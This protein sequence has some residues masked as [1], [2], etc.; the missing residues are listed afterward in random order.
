MFDLREHSGLIRSLVA[1]E[2]K[3]DENWRWSVKAINKSKASIFW[4]YLEYLECR[5]TCFTLELENTGEGWWLNGR[6]E[7]GH[8]IFTEIVEDDQ[9]PF[10]NTP[11]E[12][13]IRM[14]VSSIAGTAHNCY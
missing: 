1:E 10:L 9:M 4:G 8:S 12:E 13:A 3:K 11:I 2:N 6:N 14:A 5:T 7:H